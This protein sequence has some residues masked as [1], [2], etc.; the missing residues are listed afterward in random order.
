MSNKQIRL[1]LEFT[2]NGEA[3][4]IEAEPEAT[5]L[6]VLRDQLKLTGVKK[7]CG[8]GECGSCTVLVDGRPMASCIFPAMKARGREITTIEGLSE[9]DSLHPIQE[10]FLEAGAVQCGYCTPGM[11]MSAKGLLDRNDNPSVEEI[12][13]GMS[14]NICRCTGYVQIEEAVSLAAEKIRKAQAD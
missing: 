13:E 4:A 5:L 12:R 6:E 11:I 2:L 10:A 14:G 8:E 1:P 9:G 3:V 7:G